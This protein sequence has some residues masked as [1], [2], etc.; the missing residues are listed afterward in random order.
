[1]DAVTNLSLN[2]LAMIALGGFAVFVA[3]AWF[4][5]RWFIR[6]IEE[7]WSQAAD[8][9]DLEYT[10]D[11]K[12]LLHRYRDLIRFPGQSP[13]IFDALRGEQDGIRLSL[14]SY[15]S[16]LKKKSGFGEDEQK[17]T[18]TFRSTYLILEHDR[19]HC[20]GFFLR[21]QG[22]F[23]LVG[24]ILGEQDI[25]FATDADFSDSFVLQGRPVEAI[26]EYFDAGV[27]AVFLRR[28]NYGYS[29]RGQPGQLALESQRALQPAEVSHLIED[30]LSLARD[31]IPAKF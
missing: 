4:G 18:T 12:D 1:M 16:T 28:K 23:D 6:D 15:H 21:R 13:A 3:L 22:I 27:R 14:L 24:A 2:Q 7:D 25:E 11:N 20:P 8:R 26:R 9:L 10:T 31:L 29:Y 5:V 30:G 17:H 19:L